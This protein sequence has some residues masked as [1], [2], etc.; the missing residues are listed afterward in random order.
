VFWVRVGGRFGIGL[1]GVGR[2]GMWFAKYYISID[3]KINLFTFAVITKRRIST[4][5]T[6]IHP[7]LQNRFT[8]GGKQ[9]IIR[10]QEGKKYAIFPKR[11]KDQVKYLDESPKYIN[12]NIYYR[13]RREG[14]RTP[15]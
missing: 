7:T 10:G 15:Y 9:P 2:R 5:E 3:Y 4:G 11:K 6:G 14:D 8:T 12:L 13:N 1:V